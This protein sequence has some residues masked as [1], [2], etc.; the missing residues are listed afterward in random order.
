MVR[1]KL[2]VLY[3]VETSALLFHVSAGHKGYGAVGIDVVAGILRVVFNDKDERVVGVDGAVGDGLN[4]HSDR[5]V[6]IRL[7]QLRRV[8]PETAGVAEVSGV[9]VHEADQAQATAVRRWRSW[10]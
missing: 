6:V 2:M 3:C 5:V 4:Q 10:R 1:T 7:L 8:Q 9:I